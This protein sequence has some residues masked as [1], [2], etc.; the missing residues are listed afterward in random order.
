[1]VLIWR[2]VPDMTYNVFGGTLNLIQSLM[3]R[4]WTVLEITFTGRLEKRLEQIA[5]HRAPVKI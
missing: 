4:C 1:M 5:K 2:P 3:W